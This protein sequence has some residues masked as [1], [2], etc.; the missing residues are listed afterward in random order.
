[1]SDLGNQEIALA[2]S[3]RMWSKKAVLNLVGGQKTGLPPKD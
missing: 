1:M 3:G 2:G